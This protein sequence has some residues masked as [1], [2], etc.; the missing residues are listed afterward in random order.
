MAREKK[1][2]R[3]FFLPGKRKQV[4]KIFPAPTLHPNGIGYWFI[5]VY[6]RRRQHQV[7]RNFQI[8]VEHVS[9]HPL[10]RPF[11]K[12]AQMGGCCLSVQHPVRRRGKLVNIP[13]SPICVNKIIK[14]N[15]PRVLSNINK[16]KLRTINSEFYWRLTCWKYCKKRYP[17]M[18]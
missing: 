7:V 4:L 3:V 6:A 10:G 16:K 2:L 11:G 8:I 13:L 18:K 5:K 9:F 15:S 14:C 1:G 17:S 12:A